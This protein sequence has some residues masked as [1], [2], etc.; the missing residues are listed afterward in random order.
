MK[1]L[2]TYK[3]GRALWGLQLLL[4][5]FYAPAVLA[6]SKLGSGEL[7]PD[8][9]AIA[10]YWHNKL[11]VQLA[12]TEV[13]D[14]KVPGG[15]IKVFSADD[16]VR[17]MDA[18]L[19][20]LN[21]WID[22]V[23]PERRAGGGKSSGLGGALP[24]MSPDELQ[25]LVGRVEDLMRR[26][27]AVEAKVD[28]L[29]KGEHK[30][31]FK[32]VSAG[33]KTLFQVDAYGNSL[34]QGATGEGL[35]HIGF[36]GNGGS[37]SAI[38]PDG[39]FAASIG[40]SGG[41]LQVQSAEAK[42]SA[43]VIA[44]DKAGLHLTSG[45]KHTDLAADEDLFGLKLSDGEKPAA[46]LGTVPGKGVAL[47]LFNEAGE[48]VM[49]AG[50]NPAKNN[51]GLVA[52]GSGGQTV[53]WI[54]AEADGS[55]LA[56]V[57]AADGSPAAALVGKERAAVAYNQAGNPVATISKSGKSEG[58]T[59]VARNPDGD[60]IF[61]AGFAAEYGGGEACVWRA[62]RSNTFCLGLGMPGMGVGK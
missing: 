2:S 35:I 46:S 32:V 34:F 33:G 14:P 45:E 50:A 37:I 43:Y 5:V 41:M 51:A 10:T 31:P 9:A 8:Q 54:S 7:P 4:C 38:S 53:A 40:A 6:E 15:T 30:A 16:M 55:G 13:A 52:V 1:A 39:G 59:V 36:V 57:F 44:S 23:D 26:M 28:A 60:G 56:Q 19:A 42:T 12:P 22:K 47:R 61:A 21:F 3:L 27:D 25:L 20:E 24:P 49:S 18:T 11:D 62:K 29:M 48:Q 58:G 17:F